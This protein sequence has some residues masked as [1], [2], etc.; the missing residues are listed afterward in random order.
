MG[1]LVYHL[2][3]TSCACGRHIKW[4]LWNV[5]E[6]IT[7]WHVFSVSTNKQKKKRFCALRQELWNTF[8]FDLRKRQ[9]A[10]VGFWQTFRVI[11]VSAH[12]KQWQVHTKRKRGTHCSCQSSEAWSNDTVLNIWKAKEAL[13]FYGLNGEEDHGGLVLL[14]ASQAWS[15][16]LNHHIVSLFTQSA[17]N[18]TGL[19]QNK[20]LLRT[21]LQ[22]ITFFNNFQFATLLF[23]NNYLFRCWALC[24]SFLMF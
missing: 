6:Y 9:I 8:H 16:A 2:S 7:I 5:K 14:Q 4:L 21:L 3:L 23:L 20:M 11:K 1:T 10:A 12:L 18:L 19:P 15:S 17:S 24:I 13:L 22:K